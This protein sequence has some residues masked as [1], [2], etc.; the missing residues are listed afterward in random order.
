MTEIKGG[1][2][3]S[4]TE[5]LRGCSCFCSGGGAPFAAASWAGMEY[6]TCGCGC[7][8]FMSEHAA[9]MASIQAP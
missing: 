2:K 7:G 3:A 5:A 4:N 9:I 8:H 6:S 1:I